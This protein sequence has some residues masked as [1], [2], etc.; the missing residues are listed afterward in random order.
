M[1]HKNNILSILIMKVEQA[2]KKKL[3]F[4]LAGIINYHAVRLSKGVSESARNIETITAKAN[5][6]SKKW[7]YC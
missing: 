5:S 7:L 2:P 1:M 6:H 3:K 4:C